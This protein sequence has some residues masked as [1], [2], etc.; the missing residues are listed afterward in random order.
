VN[1]AYPVIANRKRIY[2]LF[3]KESFIKRQPSR[4]LAKPLAASAGVMVTLKGME[5]I[6]LEVPGA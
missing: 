6:L 3:A 1:W 5:A 4:V 2:L